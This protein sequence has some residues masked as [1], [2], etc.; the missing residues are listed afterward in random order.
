M[1]NALLCENVNGVPTDC[2]P[3][4]DVGTV[5]VTPPIVR[6]PTPSLSDRVHY[7]FGV[8]IGA[9]ASISSVITSV[10]LTEGRCREVN[11]V[12]ARWI[13][14][15]GL[16]KAMAGRTVLVGGT[17]YALWRV[18]HGKTRTF[19]LMGVFAFTTWNAVHDWRVYE[20]NRRR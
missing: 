8:G 10:C 6:P 9:M 17:T 14:D 12:M 19:A 11:S 7:G 4:V 18:T 5:R 13:T 20:Q 1:P 15:R 3:A 2:V 16:V